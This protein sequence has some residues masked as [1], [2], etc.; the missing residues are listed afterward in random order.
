[1]A[2]SRWS[3]TIGFDYGKAFPGMEHVDQIMAF[4]QLDKPARDRLLASQRAYASSWYVYWHISGDDSQGREG[5]L[6]WVGSNRVSMR[7]WGTYTYDHMKFIATRGRWG[8]IPGYGE[9]EDQRDCF[10]LANAVGEWLAEIEECFPA[11]AATG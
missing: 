1:M 6:L 3:T 7:D 4:V 11:P 2:Y 8:D 5:Q 10:N 9:C